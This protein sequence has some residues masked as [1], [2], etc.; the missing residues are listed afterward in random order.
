MSKVKSGDKLRH[1]GSPVVRGQ[2]PCSQS[3]V[4]RRFVPVPMALGRNPLSGLRDRLG[5]FQGCAKVLGW[6]SQNR[7]WAGAT[8]PAWL[9]GAILFGG[10]LGPVLLL[11]GL[12][13]L[14]R[15]TASLLLNLEGVFT[16]GA[17]LVRL[18]R[19]L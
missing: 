6:K 14:A 18:P 1:P 19:S 3:D 9:M 7:L 11:Q 17:S 10:A 8:C 2:H 4:D 5:S 15:G 16:A 13:R 12:A